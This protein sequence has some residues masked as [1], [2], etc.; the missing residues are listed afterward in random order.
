MSNKGK[1]TD[2]TPF[3]RPAGITTTLDDECADKSIRQDLY[4]KPLN[5]TPAHLVK[6]RNTIRQIPGVRQYHRGVYEDPRDYEKL[7]HGVK[8][9]ESDHVPDCIK[10]P[11][12]SGT[13]H[14]L[15]ELNEKKYQRTWREPLGKGILRNY[16]FPDEVKKDS[17]KFG[18]PT[19]GYY[20]A[21]EV[22][23][24]GCLLDEPEEV[25]AM[26]RKT[27]GF[28]EPGEQK[29][30]N[31]SWKFNKTTHT[32]GKPQTLELDG[33]KKSLLMDQ[34]EGL[35]PP[36]KLQNKHAEDFRQ[37]TTDIVG[38]S[39]YHGTLLPTLGPDHVF[40]VKNDFGNAWSAGKCINGDPAEMT[41][42]H[43]ECDPDLG[44]D[45]RYKS[46][47]K[48]L[49]PIEY[50]MNKVFGIPSIRR[51]LKKRCVTSV[52]DNRNYG[53]EKDAFELLYPHPCAP[54]GVDDED[55]DKPYTKQEILEV[56]N[57]NK[58]EVPQ[59]EFELVF[60]VGLKNYPNDE[61][62]LSPHQFIAT[63]K[64]FKREYMKYRTLVKV[65]EK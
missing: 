49:K 34:S 15:N 21:K 25:K 9:L 65:P 59:D 31:Y 56:L 51:D 39:K 6:F 53:D 4:F 11:S 30:R 64:N 38:K 22:I 44:R 57:E 13:K 7:V 2:F 41:S 47:L 48:N 50:D 1:F 36:T 58:I 20:N 54:R 63:L 35:Y 33:A 29:D 45:F 18:I 17:F 23:Y 46:K 62:K 24:N 12:L 60:T 27:H 28:T 3:I 14:F 61:E 26:Y 16:K 43:V 40:G 5:D 10:N 32:F 55:F 8:T 19:T 42:K 37:A 52:T